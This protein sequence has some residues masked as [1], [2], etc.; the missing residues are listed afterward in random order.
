ML[1]THHINSESQRIG[2]LQA[3]SGGTFSD[4]TITALK[5][6][7]KLHRI[8]LLNSPYFRRRLLDQYEQ[9]ETSSNHGGVNIHLYL[10]LPPSK[11]LTEE[12]L[13]FTLR[14][15]YDVG[16]KL[17][18]QE[19]RTDN[20][21]GILVL[22]TFLEMSDLINY[23]INYIEISVKRENVLQFT[24]DLEC[25]FHLLNI[26]PVSILKDVEGLEKIDLETLN[27]EQM[28]TQS[29]RLYYNKLFITILS[30]I[31]LLATPDSL[32][33]T[34]A[35]LIEEELLAKLSPMWLKSVLSSD[36]LV[37]ESEFEVTLPYPFFFSLSLSLSLS[38]LPSPLCFPRLSLL[39]PSAANF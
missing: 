38:F 22:S 21:V 28:F 10:P 35:P 18:H 24:Q 32:N 19:M 13:D 12:C 36:F 5:K 8:V 23:C 14:D 30:Y 1:S 26:H 2:S 3:F 16:G 39:F 9:K 34:H 20:V 4:I 7:Y 33:S 11:L 31:C 29:L 15:L 27:P 6:S 37:I 17:R 25:L